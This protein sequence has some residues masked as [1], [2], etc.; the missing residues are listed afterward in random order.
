VSQLVVNKKI[1]SRLELLSFV[2]E[3]QREGKTNLAQ[4]IANRGSKV[5]EA[6]IV[7]FYCTCTRPTLEYASQVFHHSLP[8]YLSDD[9]ERVQK[10]SFA[11]I[12]RG[13]PYSESLQ[14]SGI[15]SLSV[16]RQTLCEKLFLKISTDSGH[17]LHAL[18]PPKHH[19]K[20]IT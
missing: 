5:P 8:K 19:A 13:Q 9:L 1:K 7:N 20:N 17:K 4:F 18:L 15:N 10:R 11:I 6:Y 2:Q 16:Q 3:Q 12:Y 14:Q